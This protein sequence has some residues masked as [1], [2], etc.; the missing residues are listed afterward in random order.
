MVAEV[1]HTQDPAGA[2]D[3]QPK[4]IPTKK[5]IQQLTQFAAET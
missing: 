2:K 1:C 5:K 3:N 4:R